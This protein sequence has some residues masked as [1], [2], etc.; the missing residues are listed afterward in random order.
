MTRAA[1]SLATD[2]ATA[3]AL[4]L[5]QHA[6]LLAAEARAT[7]AEAEAHNRALLIEKMQ[8]I[9]AKLRHEQFGQSSERSAFI[10]QLELKLAD[11]EENASQA[12]AAAQLAAS[13]A[14]R[15]KIAAEAF[16][17]RTPASRPLPH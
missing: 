6:A 5:T 3:H 11:L 17:R 14:S 8:F 15:R 16:E 12:E 9:I 7:L 4:I 13:P 2:L 10:E 1:D